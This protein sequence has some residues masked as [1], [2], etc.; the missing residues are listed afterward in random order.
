MPAGTDEIESLA[1]SDKKYIKKYIE[2]LRINNMDHEVNQDYGI[3]YIIKNH[4][5]NKDTLKLIA[6]RAS[7]CCGQHGDEN[8]D[9]LLEYAGLRKF[10]KEKKTQKLLENC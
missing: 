9:L 3:G 6:V 4:R 10:L 8:I 2:F 1:F 5:W 7:E